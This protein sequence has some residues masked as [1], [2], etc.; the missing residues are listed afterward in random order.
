[1][2][3]EFCPKAE[4]GFHCGH[5]IHR[6]PPRIGLEQPSTRLTAKCCWCDALAEMTFSVVKIAFPGHGLGSA[7]EDEVWALPVGW[8]KGDA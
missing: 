4:D 2:S 6:H 3:T 7:Y 5:E 8:H 1:M